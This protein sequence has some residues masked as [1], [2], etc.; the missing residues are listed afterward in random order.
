MVQ[1]TQM[2]CLCVI[3]V[4]MAYSCSTTRHSNRGEMYDWKHA[5]STGALHLH[6]TYTE[7]YCGGAEI[8][9]SEYPRPQPWKGERFIRAAWPDST[10]KL[11]IND[12]RRPILDTIHMN[13]EGHGCLTLP[14]GQYLLLER[15][16]VDDRRYRQLLRDHAQPRL[17]TEAIDTACMIHWLYGP[18]GAI[19]IT[20]GDTLH[21]EFPMRGQCPWYNKPCVRYNGPLPP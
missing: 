19:S 17:H 18:F 8:D 16:R 13:G 5:S 11:A 1:R 21:I 2:K 15:D 12:L 14:A 9:P 7:P 10:G 4:L 20:S 6:C 3:I